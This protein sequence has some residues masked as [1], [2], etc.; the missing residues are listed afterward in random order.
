[1]HIPIE[2]LSC[3]VALLPEHILRIK[4]CAKYSQL[5]EILLGNIF[6]QLSPK[7]MPKNG[8]NFGY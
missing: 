3:P 8:K 6:H 1:M 7:G 4:F 2:N 5:D